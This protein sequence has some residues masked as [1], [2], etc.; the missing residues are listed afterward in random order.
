MV[1]TETKGILLPASACGLTSST[2]FQLRCLHARISG[3]RKKGVDE[4]M[5]S[6]AEDAEYTIKIS[7]PGHEFERQVGEDVAS[8]I[9]TFVMS[10]GTAGLDGSGT[11][12]EQKNQ[13]GNQLLSKDLTPRQF[14][15]QKKP[16]SN[17][18]R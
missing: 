10:G 18:E 15:A 9:I 4:T 12:S 5:A 2:T 16:G 17:Y 8:K 1:S 3:A 11:G 14:M 13:P 7:G 6:K